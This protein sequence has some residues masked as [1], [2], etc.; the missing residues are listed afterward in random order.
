MSYEEEKCGRC[1]ELVKFEDAVF[2]SEGVLHE[3]CFKEKFKNW[4]F[5]RKFASSRQWLRGKTGIDWR[6]RGDSKKF[7]MKKFE[8]ENPELV[9]RLKGKGE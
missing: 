8:K 6:V 1:G 7:D 4:W 3:K 2:W 5:I 9:A